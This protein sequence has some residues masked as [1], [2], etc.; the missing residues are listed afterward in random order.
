MPFVE[1]PNAF[2]C[3][4]ET[5]PGCDPNIRPE[6][7][8]NMAVSFPQNS[9]TCVWTCGTP[10]SDVY[11]FSFGF[12][13]DVGILYGFDLTLTAS[14][15]FNVDNVLSILLVDFS[16]T[17][18]ERTIPPI[19][20]LFN[21]TVVQNSSGVFI[22][23][24]TMLPIAGEYFAQYTTQ[25]E[26]E[27]FLLVFDIPT[28]PNSLVTVVQISV[29]LQRFDVC[30]PFWFGNP[31]CASAADSLNKIYRAPV[32]H[33][34][35]DGAP[36]TPPCLPPTTTAPET[37]MTFPLNL[38]GPNFVSSITK[39]VALENCQ[40]TCNSTDERLNRLIFTL[41]ETNLA[42]VTINS[43][44]KYFLGLLFEVNHI[45]VLFKTTFS[46]ASVPNPVVA[47]EPSIV[48]WNGNA[49]F[50]NPD[51]VQVNVAFPI[52]LLPGQSLSF[53]ITV[54]F[55]ILSHG[56]I[57]TK[58]FT[59]VGFE[60]TYLC[61]TA[62]ASE[63]FC[64]TS[65]IGHNVMETRNPQAG[66]FLPYGPGPNDCTDNPCPVRPGSV[67][68]PAF[69]IQNFSC[70]TD[71]SR[72][73]DP[74]LQNL[75]IYEL[76]AENPNTGATSVAFRINHWDFHFQCQGGSSFLPYFSVNADTFFVTTNDSRI[77][78]PQLV[79]GSLTEFRVVFDPP[80]VVLPEQSQCFT[81]EFYRNPFFPTYPC[82]FGIGHF[83]NIQVYCTI[84]DI[85]AGNCLFPSSVAASSDPFATA[86]IGGH[87]RQYTCDLCTA[88]SIPN[89]TVGARIFY[90]FNGNGVVD[91]NDSYIVNVPVQAVDVNSQLVL[92][93]TTTDANGYAIF[94]ATALF[95]VSSL[96]VLVVPTSGI[97]AGYKLT[98]P[99]SPL[100]P[101]L[102][103]VFT[104]SPP[105]SPN[106]FPGAAFTLFLGG[107]AP[108]SL[109][110]PDLGPYPNNTV[111]ITYVG[112]NCTECTRSKARPPPTL[113]CSDTVCFNA[114]VRRIVD[115]TFNVS[116]FGTS[117]SGPASVR[118]E[119][120]QAQ[121][122]I[123]TSKF[124][125]A[126][127]FAY[128]S[129]DNM[130][131]ITNAHGAAKLSDKGGVVLS[132]PHMN[133][134][135]YATFGWDS[136]PLGANVL[137]FTVRFSYCALDDLF[138]YNVTVTV[139]NNDCAALLKG[140]KSCSINGGHVDFRQCYAQ[141]INLASE[142]C[143]VGCPNEIASS[144]SDSDGGI[145]IGVHNLN[146]AAAIPAPPPPPPTEDSSDDFT[147]AP[148]PTFGPPGMS[149]PIVAAIYT[150]L[151]GPMC[152][153]KPLILAQKC[154]DHPRALAQC[155]GAGARGLI[156]VRYVLQL[157]PGAEGEAGEALVTLVRL[158]P[159]STL[160]CGRFDP[161][162][163]V[164][165][166]RN[167]HPREHR[168]FILSKKVVQS[169]ETLTVNLGF[170]KFD[171]VTNVILDVVTIEC[172]P[173]GPLPVLSYNATVR[174]FTSGCNKETGCTTNEL[175]SNIV[176]NNLPTECTDAV[177]INNP[178]LSGRHR[179]LLAKR[180]IDSE[181]TESSDSN[182]D[183]DDDDILDDD[184]DSNGSHDGTS[185]G[186]II[187]YVLIGLAIVVTIGAL[188]YLIV[189][190][191]GQKKD[192]RRAERTPGTV[193]FGKRASL[194]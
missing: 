41:T 96:F 70:Y 74:R 112:D 182:A 150:L 92:A 72:T 94:N 30:A 127:G 90:D 161:D 85:E 137:S 122:N 176:F 101:F 126:D 75:F 194:Q 69:L 89:N 14:N 148:T 18:L 106:L 45:A 172:L 105:T 53:N 17:D 117:P 103:S 82:L 97:P 125:C 171:S 11:Q 153:T 145:V 158:S 34:I 35:G 10:N 61:T 138:A 59:T 157:K 8:I 23:K 51:N 48:G 46:P 104:G 156:I 170:L 88:G 19:S 136:I 175:I 181:K 114:S 65:D 91:F 132:A 155:K 7:P 143:D 25:F 177:V 54:F 57:I 163:I 58:A 115:L 131:I 50:F 77:I 151:D 152:V 128:N 26:T 120:L 99:Y 168:A 36:C 109:C 16:T 186:L 130:F 4:L 78:R 187:A 22:V 80:L 144:D 15:A 3:F 191:V 81:L 13:H 111:L 141:Q 102:H 49:V 86:I 142:P 93:G 146:N 56:S 180:S 37:M 9:V 184:D 55:S 149:T 193:S 66:S 166:T 12:E 185:T 73:S 95:N 192:T 123:G 79:T 119:F 133:N 39:T 189:Y 6:P 44:Q 154:G 38:G 108:I 107:F 64:S 29:D 87:F 47:S 160:F 139:D 43:A 100:N 83:D 31:N 183:D 1:L 167:G 118:V 52:A 113:K 162:L 21:S 173:T 164:T 71:C 84:D 190:L 179:H 98:I 63:Q 28:T 129:T 33:L 178:E 169:S 159:S 76:C 140:W 5:I 20:S 116:N 62:L 121:D 40:W 68:F 147:P 60:K 67:L 188:I 134:N 27:R 165:V 174:L 32:Y 135:A 110:K 24:F 2:H 124:I 42:P